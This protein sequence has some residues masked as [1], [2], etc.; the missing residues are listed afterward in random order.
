MRYNDFVRPA[1]NTT[2][3]DTGSADIASVHGWT[4]VG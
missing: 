1:V 2:C 3:M 4:I